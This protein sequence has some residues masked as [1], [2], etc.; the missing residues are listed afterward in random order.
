[1][2]RYRRTLRAGVTAILAASVLAACGGSSGPPTLTWFFNPDSGGQVKLAAECTKASGGKYKIATQV[3]P[4]DAS[5]QRQQLV[6]RLAAKDSAI[7]LMSLDPVFV[8]EFAEAGFLADVPQRYVGPFEQNI[9]KPA[10]DAST[11]KKKLVAAPFWANTQLLWYRKSLAKKAGLDMSKPVT[12]DQII[13]AAKSQKRDIGVQASLY[14]GYTVWINSLV[15]GAGGKILDNPGAIAK[16][17][18]LGLDSQAGRDA[19]SV[20]RKLAGAGVGGPALSS[21]NEDAALGLFTNQ[22]S[23]MFMTIWPYVW[24]AMDTPAFRKTR[25]SDVGWTYYPQTV[26]G[27]QSAPPFGGIELGVSKYSAHQNLAWDAI[28]CIRTAEHQ[29]EY[30]LS[31]SNPPANTTAFSDPKVIKTFPMSALIRAS[32]QRAAPRPQTQYYGDLSAALQQSFS[33]PTS[34]DSGTP[35]SAAKFIL[36]VLKGEKLL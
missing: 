5:A 20:I 35:K 27:K 3:L 24:L 17:V 18:K 14:E 1:M 21:T 7:S 8:G 36:E 15:A 32:L 26:A 9:V 29:A 34:V 30:F 11:W 19:A 13:A 23:S 2:M 4:S 25:D 31:S 16:N 10:V 6:T 33:P 12:W 28:S 22:A